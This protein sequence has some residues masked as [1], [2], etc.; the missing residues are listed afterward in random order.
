M[1]VRVCV[2]VCTCVCVLLR[3]GGW[4]GGAIQLRERA[5]ASVCSLLRGRCC[6]RQAVAA[7]VFAYALQSC[8]FQSVVDWRVW[9]WWCM[10]VR[11]L[12]GDGGKGGVGGWVVGRWE[13]GRVRGWRGGRVVEGRGERARMFTKF[14]CGC[15]HRLGAAAP[16]A[17]P[18][19]SYKNK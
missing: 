7:A 16:A 5:R 13:R 8:N 15:W 9:W 10:G 3:V 19:Q 1:V 17:R 2:Y 6:H 18:L 11:G 12:V 14:R 4:V